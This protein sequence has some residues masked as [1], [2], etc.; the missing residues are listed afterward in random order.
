VKQVTL[1]SLE[2]QK[3]KHLKKKLK[4]QKKDTKLK[5]RKR[6]T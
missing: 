3:A 4:K 6:E 5:K 1:A 2:Q